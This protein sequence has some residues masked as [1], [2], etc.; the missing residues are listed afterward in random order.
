M[1]VL[2][3]H[4]VLW[5]REERLNLIGFLLVIVGLLLSVV[6]MADSA[7]GILNPNPVAPI[8]NTGEHLG[9]VFIGAGILF[10]GIVTLRV[11]TLGKCDLLPLITSVF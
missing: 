11:K 3:L 10:W 5:K 4:A 1:G 2:G 6:D 8:I 9:L 7:L